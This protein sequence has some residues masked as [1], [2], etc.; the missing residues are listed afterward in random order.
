MNATAFKISDFALSPPQNKEDLLSLGREM[1]D[2]LDRINQHFDGLFE[3]IDCM[4]GV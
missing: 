1:C 2:E 3:E 4:S